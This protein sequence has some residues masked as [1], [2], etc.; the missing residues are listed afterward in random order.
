[1]GR[2]LWSN[3]ATVPRSSGVAAGPITGLV[4]IP[5]GLLAAAMGI[6]VFCCADDTRF[7]RLPVILTLVM[8]IGLS[9]HELA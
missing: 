5:S 8:G 4:T 1:M 3:P 9:A 2:I 7:R 6:A